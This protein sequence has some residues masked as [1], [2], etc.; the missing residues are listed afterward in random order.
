MR[1]LL[2]QKRQKF[3]AVFPVLRDELLAYLKQEG[4]PADAVE[5]YQRVRLSPLLLL[6]SLGRSARA[7]LTVRP[8]EPRLQRPRGK[9][10]PRYLGG[11][12]CSDP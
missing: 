1:R 2:A 12:L 11:G 7:M 4:M 10:Q 9:A 6:S 5:W 8:A 3:E